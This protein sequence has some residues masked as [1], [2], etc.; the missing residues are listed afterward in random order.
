[1]CSVCPSIHLADVAERLDPQYVKT[2]VP[3]SRFTSGALPQDGSSYRGMVRA[4]LLISD[5]QMVC[6]LL[7]VM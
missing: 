3:V 7:S 5:M 4:P 6:P 2:L 1:M